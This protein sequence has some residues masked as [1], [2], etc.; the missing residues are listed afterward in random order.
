VRSEFFYRCNYEDSIVVLN[1]TPSSL[2]ELNAS[3][4][5]TEEIANVD[6]EDLVWGSCAYQ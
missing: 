6:R 4:F 5:R 3:M 1:V 2:V